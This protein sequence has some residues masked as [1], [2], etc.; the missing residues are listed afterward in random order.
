M[1]SNLKVRP[2]AFILSIS[3]ILT[4][5]CKSFQ[6]TAMAQTSG[7]PIFEGWYADPEGVVFGK[8][9][10]IYPTFSAKYT[11]QV[12]LDAFSSKDLVNWE[13]HSR[14]LDTSI[15][16]WAKQA[17]WAPAAI[18]KDGKYFLFF[19]ANDVQ[20]P[21]GPMW[22]TEN[23]INHYGG[24]GIAVAE[25][26]SG[27][28]RDYLEKPLVSDFYNDAQPIDQFVFKDVD[29]T[30]YFFYGGWSHCNMGILNDDFTGFI[31]FEDGEIFK[32]ITPE[33]YVEGP[34]MFLRNNTYYLMW[35][36]GGW[37]NDTYKVAYAMG[38]S[39][40]GPFKRIGTILEADRSIATGAGHNSV[41]QVPGTDDWYM[42][43][44][45]RPIPNLDRDHRVV[46]IDKME[47]NADGTIKNII[48]TFD[49]VA[50]QLIS[51]SKK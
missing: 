42:I 14:V 50:P 49:G 7:N 38:N 28:F 51:T 16:K 11:D 43:Y 6:N 24:I 19:S 25:S 33:G 13:K 35:S 22:D 31:P 37:T 27:P 32:E 8:E 30:H 9:Y 3:L 15:V 41:I 47:F 10:W 12:F 29:G 45:R 4:M 18:E 44:H 48:M 34:L 5:G 20:R 26:P 1:N 21:G 2:I 40:R 23:D 17:I 46:C 36:E 39:P